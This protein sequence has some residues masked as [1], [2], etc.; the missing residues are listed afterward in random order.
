LSLLVKVLAILITP[1]L[2][3]FELVFS[4]SG[5]RLREKLT[6]IKKLAPPE[7][8]VFHGH[9]VI[10]PL[11]WL[12]IILIII[13]AWI[14]Y[15]FYKKRIPFLQNDEKLATMTEVTGADFKENGGKLFKRR[16][17]PPEDAIRREIFHLEKFAGK[18]KLGRNPAETL[19]EWWL[20]EGFAQ[21][22]EIKKIY[23]HVRYGEIPANPEEIANVKAF[24]TRC[25]QQL[26]ET[27]KQ[28]KQKS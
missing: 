7:A 5:D 27:A 18:L 25:I 16:A 15:Y 23:N 11:W 12:W 28:N 3:L 1:L 24:I 17:K 9:D 13:L 14:I 26:K 22:E 10:S 2:Y 8:Q 20:R 4:H 19:D 6:K 21:T